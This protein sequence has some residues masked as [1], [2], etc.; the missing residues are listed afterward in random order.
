[1]NFRLLRDL[2]LEFSTD[3]DKPLTVIRAENET[4]KTTILTAL[5]W[6]LFGDD[7]LP[8]PKSTYRLHPIDWDRAAASAVEISVELE[9]EH[10]FPPAAS[11]PASP[12]ETSIFIAKRV[13]TEELSEDGATWQRRNPTFQLLRRTQNGFA[14]VTPSGGVLIL[15]QML[16][17]NLKDLFFTDGDRALSFI[18]AD[19]SQ[20]D[21]R[22]LV[23][24]AIRDMLGFDILTSARKHV[25]RAVAQIR[26]Q[27]STATSGDLDA[28]AKALAEIDAKLEY[29]RSA[30]EDAERES[31]SLAVQISTLDHKI[32]G[33][34]ERGD[35]DSLLKQL[36]GLNES[37]ATTRIEITDQRGRHGTQF[38][39]MT[40]A[41]AL[42]AG[43]IERARAILDD[44]KER[45]RLP[46]TTVPILRE[47]LDMG[48]CICGTPLQ[49][50]GD[51]YRYMQSTIEEQD[52]ASWLDDR[53]THLRVKAQEAQDGD[54]AAHSWGAQLSQ[55]IGERTKRE[56]RMVELEHQHKELD[57]T[58]GQI[59]DT[60][61]TLLRKQRSQ[62]NTLKDAAIRKASL[63]AAT[64][65]RLGRDKK[66]REAEYDKLL[67]A[68]SAMERVRNQLLATNDILGVLKNTYETIEKSELPAVSEAMHRYFLE[69]VG[70]GDQAALIQS[71]KVNE[72]YD[73][74]VLGPERRTLDADRDL[75]GASRRAL[76]L[77]FILALTEVSGVNAPN[78]IDTPLGMMS[79]Q[80]KRA[81]LETAVSHCQQLI[82]FLTRS[83]IRDIEDLIDRFA[84]RVITLSN[85]VHFPRFLKNR[86]SAA[87]ARTMRCGCSHRQICSLCERVG[88]DARNEL[89]L[90]A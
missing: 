17:S 27:A 28:L 33:A 78:V 77:A 30:K 8:E 79:L 72:H 40:L 49:P 52:K 47:R 35:K 5:Q 6:V 65:E 66:Q 44:L 76:T 86:P 81:V 57:V 90:R 61:L 68:S 50:G 46:R 34:L 3:P 88:D 1:V 51:A 69:M 45:G 53:L 58:I 37:L 10:T 84:G 43:P 14:P 60:D 71:A 85:S 4:G 11:A 13:V 12:P 87:S 24:G 62:N 55:V 39:E 16:G 26:Q 67:K 15:H 64:A 7:A 36:K 74:V 18:T 56:M 75:N 82:L 80:I 32:E 89:V 9:F 21:K 63:A 2:E 70:G 42:C 25:E 19:I 29:E 20:S 41:H 31:Q 48:I 22:K 59:P 83:E 54:G 38:Q 73:I 23:Q